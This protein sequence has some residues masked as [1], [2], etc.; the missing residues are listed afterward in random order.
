MN[1]SRWTS[2]IAPLIVL[3]V[4]VTIVL[5]IVGEDGI[6]PL[7]DGDAI[8]AV[9]L[10][11]FLVIVYLQV[12]QSD[13]KRRTVLIHAATLATY[14]IVILLDS[15]HTSNGYFSFR[16]AEK[17]ALFMTVHTGISYLVLATKTLARPRS[18]KVVAGRSADAAGR[19]MNVDATQKTVSGLPRLNVVVLVFLG[20]IEAYLI[21]SVAASMG[22]QAGGPIAQLILMLLA[23][24]FHVYLQGNHSK[25]WKQTKRIHG[26]IGGIAVVVLIALLVGGPRSDGIEESL[27]FVG[28]LYWVV[29]Y[30]VLCIIVYLN[31]VPKVAK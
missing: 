29:S 1:H 5:N 11:A 31:K 26:I 8:R 7:S 21:P 13:N 14:A 27:M 30:A 23:S 3:P 24:A 19:S 20:L 28:I 12:R 2:R 6:G 9:V 10:S 18:R 17:F 25:N 22:A 4:V 15:D 16:P